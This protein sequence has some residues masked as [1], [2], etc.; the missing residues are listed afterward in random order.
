MVRVLGLGWVLIVVIVVS[1]GSR[2]AVGLGME[3]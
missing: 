1:D 2:E 3:G